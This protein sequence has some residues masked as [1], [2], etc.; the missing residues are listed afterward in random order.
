MSQLF[1]SVHQSIVGIQYS[2]S[3]KKLHFIFSYYKI[4]DIFPVLYS[5]SL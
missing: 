5:I 4:L 2:D 3:L 1:P